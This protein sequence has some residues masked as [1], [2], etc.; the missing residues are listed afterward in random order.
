MRNEANF[1]VGRLLPGVYGGWFGVESGA[2]IG[3]FDGL[4]AFEFV[5]GVAVVALGSID[6]ALKAGE[7]V[8][9]AAEGFAEDGFVDGVLHAVFPEL[10]FDEAEAAEEELAIDE[11]VDEHALLR[12]AGV[13]SALVL[14]LEDFE[15]AG[16]FPVDDGL[17]AGI[18][19]GAEGVPGRTGLARGGAG[20]SGFLC[21][22]SIGGELF[23]CRHRA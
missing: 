19:A 23:W 21:V 4:E 7:G 12:G 8:A 14:P 5:E 3:V 20:S 16:S 10:G 13:E 1:G 18:D 11:G 22:E 2:A 9:I 6:A 17:S 15:I